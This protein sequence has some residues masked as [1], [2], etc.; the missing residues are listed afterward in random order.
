MREI[1]DI[2]QEV[3]TLIAVGIGAVLATVGGFLATMYDAWLHKREREKTAAITFGEILVSLRALMRA[4]ESA[5]GIGDPFGQL[6]MR[7]LKGSRREI[8][9]YEAS[10]S[11]LCDLQDADLRLRL[12]ALMIRLALALDGVIEA[13]TDDVRQ[14]GYE[15]LMELA[16][17]LDELVGRLAPKARQSLAHYEAM[18]FSPHGYVRP[19][20]AAADP[21]AE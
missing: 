3:S 6:T 12:S 10:R 8:D 21:A 17:G 14:G 9:A 15:F 4:C 2:G 11:A 7:L 19:P 1:P 5:H 13:E 16:P 20:L 18:P